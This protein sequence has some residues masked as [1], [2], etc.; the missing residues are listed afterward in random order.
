MKLGA[1]AWK[2]PGLHHLQYR[3]RVGGPA[4]REKW[5]PCHPP[6]YDGRAPRGAGPGS[7]TGTQSPTT[8]STGLWGPRPGRSKQGAFLW[9]HIRSQVI[10]VPQK[11][12][13]LL[14][15]DTVSIGSKLV[16]WNREDWII[17]KLFKSGVSLK[18][19]SGTLP[20]TSVALFG[21]GLCHSWDGSALWVVPWLCRVEG[22]E[23][24]FAGG[25]KGAS[26]L[27]TP[28]SSSRLGKSHHQ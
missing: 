2:L 7:A 21:C 28:G 5:G 22:T 13:L 12:R 15:N 23:L 17:L 9:G 11:L 8:E 3:C 14:R 10:C 19:S 6:A 4:T 20:I 25:V 27:Y 26:A 1:S 16:P 18:A 24:A